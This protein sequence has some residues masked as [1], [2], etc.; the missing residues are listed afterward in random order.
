MWRLDDLYVLPTR[1]P[2]ARSTPNASFLF[3]RDAVRFVQKETEEGH[4]K[5][6]LP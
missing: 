5:W 3:I 2:H 4:N 6:T 1:Y